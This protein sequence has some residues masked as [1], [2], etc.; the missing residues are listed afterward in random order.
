MAGRRAAVGLSGRLAAYAVSGAHVLVVEVPGWWET[1]AAVE[2]ALTARGWRTALSPADADVIVVCGDPG[3]QLSAVVDRVWEQ[4]PGPRARATALHTDEVG[5]ALDE[6]ALA[7]RD[8]QHQRRDAGDRAREPAGGADREDMDHGD[9]DHGDMEMAPGGIPLASGGEDRDGLEMDVLHVPLGP[10]LPHWP[11]GLV[12]RCSLQGDVV[13]EAQVEVLGPAAPSPALSA[14]ADE[15]RAARRCDGAARLLAI[16]GWDDAAAA[17]RRTRDV[18]LDGGDRDDAARQL[19]RLASRVTRSL[20]LRWMLRGLGCVDGAA[21]AARG[22]PESA[23][24]DVHDR[25]VAML[26]QSRADLRGEATADEDRA[27]ATRA[28]LPT[29]VRG[30]DVAA[31]RLIVASFDPDTVGVRRE[32]VRA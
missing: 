23:R 10:V 18:L 12:L 29:L 2:R 32:A 19:D 24:G 7:L 8:D 15:R 13:T 28:A 4:L 1:R 6:T 16:A 25:L 5:A 17:A 11:A 31:A 26:R 22:L 9:M 21:V 3:E 27:A 20:T 30:L 14:P